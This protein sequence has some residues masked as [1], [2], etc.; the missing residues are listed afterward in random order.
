[1]IKLISNSNVDIDNKQQDEYKYYYFQSKALQQASPLL[2]LLLEN[3]QENSIQIHYPYE[4]LERLSASLSEQ[5]KV[6]QLFDASCFIQEQ[7]LQAFCTWCA[8]LNEY[9]FT[10]LFDASCSF[11]SQYAMDHPLQF[12]PSI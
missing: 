9:E 3:G 11:I 7:S 10:D 4:C 8:F 12:F 6:D 2:K 5:K 1:M